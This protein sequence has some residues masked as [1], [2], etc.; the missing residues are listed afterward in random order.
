[1]ASRDSEV[2]W[3]TRRAIRTGSPLVRVSR[4][5]SS[6]GHRARARVW[7][8]IDTTRPVAALV[9]FAASA[10]APRSG[11]ARMI[12]AGSTVALALMPAW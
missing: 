11:S 3:V 9:A 7:Q 10:D 5:R 12:N 6:R 4:V 8:S 2:R 1:M